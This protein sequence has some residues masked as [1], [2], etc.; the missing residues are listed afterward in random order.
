L[1]VLFLFMFVVVL[2]LPRVCYWIQHLLLL[3]E[4]SLK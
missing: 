2:Q 3:P 1:P 4:R